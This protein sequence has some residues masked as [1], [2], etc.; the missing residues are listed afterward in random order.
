MVNKVIKKPY[1]SCIWKE[2]IEFIAC[3]EIAII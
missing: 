3:F 1:Q 2:S